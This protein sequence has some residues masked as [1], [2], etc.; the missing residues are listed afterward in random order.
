VWTLTFGK[1]VAQVPVGG[2]GEAHHA[3]FTDDRRFLWAGV[4]DDS[5]T[6]LQEPAPRGR[7]AILTS[8]LTSH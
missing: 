3:G 1:V 7:K 2:Q 6:L 5:K 8:K 4:L